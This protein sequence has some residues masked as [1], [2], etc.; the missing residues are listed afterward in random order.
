MK[1]GMLKPGMT[2]SCAGHAAALFFGLIA[3]SA[4]P[5][6]APQVQTLPVSFISEKDF[7]QLSQGVKNT[8][9]L[10]IPDP[11]PLADKIDLPK[12]VDQLAPKVAN[13]PEITTE[14]S[15]PA[16]PSKPETK[17]EAKPEAATETKQAQKPATSPTNRSRRNIARTRS[18]ICSRRTP[19]RSSPS[20]TRRRTTSARNST[21][22][23]LRKIG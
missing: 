3:I 6:E 18:P 13:K 12:P 1:P 15:K 2:I 11:K 17:P 21:P 4:Q 22:I 23:R 5:M 19:P 14:A 16:A 20:G 7:S 8:P 9:E 10:K